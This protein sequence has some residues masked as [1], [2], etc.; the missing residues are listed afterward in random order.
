MQHRF[1][2]EPEAVGHGELVDFASAA[3]ILLGPLGGAQPSQKEER[4][5]DHDVGKKHERPNL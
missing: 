3:R 4:Q 1:K 2:R 5:T